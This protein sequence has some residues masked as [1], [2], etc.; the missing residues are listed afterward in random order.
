MVAIQFTKEL[1]RCVV[2]DPGRSIKEI[3]PLFH[4]WQLKASEMGVSLAKHANAKRPLFAISSCY[5]SPRGVE[6]S[7]H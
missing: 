1:R 4:G 3:I 7:S 2:V 5:R 6:L